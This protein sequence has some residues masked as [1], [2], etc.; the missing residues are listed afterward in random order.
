MIS[1]AYKL[2]AQGDANGNTEHILFTGTGRTDSH[3]C[4]TIH[5]SESDIASPARLTFLSVIATPQQRHDITVPP[6]PVYRVAKREGGAAAVWSFGADGEWISSV[7]FSWL[8]ARPR[9]PPRRR[10]DRMRRARSAAFAR[11]A[12]GALGRGHGRRSRGRRIRASGGIAPRCI[13]QVS[14]G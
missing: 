4:G 12:G 1:A 6:R 7:E 10:S 3:G 11:A 8:A 13:A 9:T 14:E 5:L 2:F